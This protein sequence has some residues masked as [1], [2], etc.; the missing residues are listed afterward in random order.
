MV[1]KISPHFLA[2]CS[3]AAYNSKN[4]VKEWLESGGWHLEEFVDIKDT[5]CFIAS[6]EKYAVIAF[7]GTEPSHVH[8]VMSDVKYSKRAWVYG[9]VHSGFDDALEKVW[10]VV[11]SIC[12]HLIHKRQARLFLTGH[13][14]GA[15]LA[16][17]G[18]AR[19]SVL[20]MNPSLVTFGSPRVSNGAFASYMDL[21]VPNYR[22]YV[23]NNDIVTRM[24]LPKTKWIQKFVPFAWAL[25]V[26]FRHCG[27]LRYITSDGKIVKKPSVK[28]L[29]ID[30]LKG[31][32]FAGKHFLTDGSRD[33]D[34]K[35]YV[36]LLA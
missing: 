8:D 6:K 26:G 1:D 11:A 30:R 20:R 17:L 31:R 28:Q 33:H 7:R 21:A 19:F 22:R 5:E 32:W 13:S 3:L 12:S 24:P 34:I 4:G 2:E 9:K 29:C 15:S 18:A 25:P 36:R 35:K 16:T 27:K 14:L 10:G 23:N